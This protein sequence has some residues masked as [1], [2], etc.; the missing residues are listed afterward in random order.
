MLYWSENRETLNQ[1]I[2]FAG[3][4]FASC[5]IGPEPENT[6]TIKAYEKA[7][8]RHLKTVQ[9]PFLDERQYLMRLAR[10]EVT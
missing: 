2:V 9:L 6:I 4:T 10:S 7:G 3:K 8:F 1:E 5:I